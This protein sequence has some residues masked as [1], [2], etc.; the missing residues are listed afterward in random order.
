M[1]I[2]V[3]K[4]QLDLTPEAEASKAVIPNWSSRRYTHI[5]A[6]RKSRHFGRDAEIQAM[7]GNQTVVQVLDS[8]ILS[9]HSFLSVDTR[10][11]VVSTVCHPWTLD[12]GIHAE[13][14]GLQHLC[15]TMITGA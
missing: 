12:F 4:L 8:E 1:D 5:R 3:S 15:I 14:T 2:L 9:S 13:M 6:S 11:T 7:D 10:A